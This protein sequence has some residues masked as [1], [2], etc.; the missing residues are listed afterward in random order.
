MNIAGKFLSLTQGAAEG[1]LLS[2]LRS[3]YRM[4]FNLE[5]LA[6]RAKEDLME[7]NIPI[8]PKSLLTMADELAS[9][10]ST[11]LD[12]T[13]GLELSRWNSK[14]QDYEEYTVPDPRE[15]FIR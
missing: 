11:Y 8:T 2:R 14:L 13:V 4:N 3:K 9:R 5:T 7:L 1:A 6:T 12:D 15:Y 10:G